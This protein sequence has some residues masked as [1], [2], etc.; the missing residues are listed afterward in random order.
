[1]KLKPRV[2]F[3]S[4]QTII[5]AWMF[6]GMVLFVGIFSLQ[7]SAA[8]ITV[9]SAA[10]SGTGS[11]RSALVA[12][13]NGDTVDATGVSGTIQLNSGQ[14]IV[15]T[16]VTIVG[17]G[18]GTLAVKGQSGARVFNVS[19][20]L[21]V[22]ISGLTIEGGNPTGSFPANAGGGILNDLATLTVSNCVVGPNAASFGAG[23][24]NYGESGTAKL[25]L[26]NSTVSNNHS[27]TNNQGWGAGI[28]N[29]SE[30]NGNATVT[31]SNCT[32][33]GNTNNSYGGGI[34][35]DGYGGNA[36]LTIS[37]STIS[38]CA[39]G[40]T[41]LASQGGGI[42]NYAESGKAAGTATVT[43]NS[44]TLQNNEATDGGGIYSQGYDGGSAV[45]NVTNSTFSANSARDGG[46]VYTDTES[47]IASL[48]LNLCTFSGNSANYGACI[49]TWWGESGTPMPTVSI[50]N[51]I[52]NGGAAATS[53]NLYNTGIFTSQGYNLCSDT[54]SGLL[55]ASDQTNTN[56]MLGTLQ[57]N[58]GPTLT[59]ALLPGSP[60]I[61]AGNP[62]FTPPPDYDQRGPGYP[63]AINGRL[64]I[65]A[66]E[67]QVSLPLLGISKASAP[68]IIL[69]WPQSYG[70]LTLQSASTLITTNWTPITN[71]PVAGSDGQLYVTN[72]ASGPCQYFR[73]MSQ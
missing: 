53:T 69:Y 71:T 59:Y 65:G 39:V 73:L 51:S 14:L 50:G 48:S 27:L 36:Y 54:G 9:A 20:G 66:I 31:I 42:Y 8:T 12:A 40:H 22:T 67:Q 45:I 60:A 29:D 68:D 21:N 23:I 5:E 19:P 3:I 38:N 24:Y 70:H 64:D 61:N 10:D 41:S 43:I 56:P 25:T 34:Y 26:V 11:L 7:A 57:N 44:S 33:S 46:A 63:R 30:A 2:P 4:N 58:G 55:N 49:Y 6:R 15:S 13:H 72:K 62:T 32:L 47:G 52:L 17:P 1:M 35:N 16:S 28:Y 37:D 18:P